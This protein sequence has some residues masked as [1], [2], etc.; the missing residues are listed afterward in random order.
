MT[1]ALASA[2]RPRSPPGSRGGATVAV[3]SGGVVACIPWA[4][5]GLRQDSE[6]RARP[7]L[8]QGL[9]RLS[10]PS[11]LPSLQLAALS[12]HRGPQGLLF[13]GECQPI[14]HA[15]LADDQGA[16]W[17]SLQTGLHSGGSAFEKVI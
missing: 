7:A 1:R 2:R 17:S 4:T 11:G 15:R 13:S 16:I 5:G 8:S 3:W 9:G 12:S 14:P 10:L 6:L